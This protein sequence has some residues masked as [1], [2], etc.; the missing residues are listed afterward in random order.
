VEFQKPDDPHVRAWLNIP[1][2]AERLRFWSNP[3]VEINLAKEA[4]S[5]VFRLGVDWGR[6]VPLEPLKGIEDVVCL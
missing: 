6:I 5:T 3:E 4:G 1:L 2:A